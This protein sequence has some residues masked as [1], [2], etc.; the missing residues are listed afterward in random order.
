MKSLSFFLAASKIEY[1][2][3]MFVSMNG[4]GFAM[5]LSTWL[6]AA[7][8]TNKSSYVKK[9]ELIFLKVVIRN[10]LLL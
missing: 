1:V 6:S 4:K 5:L 9:F 3:S 7:K 2:P 8:F 10:D